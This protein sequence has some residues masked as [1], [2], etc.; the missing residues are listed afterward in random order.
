MTVMWLLEKLRQK[1]S[2]F[3]NKMDE[4]PFTLANEVFASNFEKLRNW[5]DQEE[6]KPKT[7]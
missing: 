5:K 1:I 3:L 2:Y 4:L 7:N 6:E